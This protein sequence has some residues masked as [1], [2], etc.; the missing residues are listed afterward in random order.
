[1]KVGLII[2]GAV[3]GLLFFT[4]VG[5][6]GWYMNVV[7]TEIG[8]SNR[9]DG[10]LNVVET[11]L[12][13]MRKILKNKYKLTTEYADKFIAVVQANAEGRKGGGLLKFSTESNAKIG[14]DDKMYTEMSNSIAG[15]LDNFKRAQNTLTDIWQVHKTY[16]KQMPNCFIIGGKV[17]SKP[18]MISSEITKE[19]IKTKK[20]SDDVM[21]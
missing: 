13:T 6:I 5:L 12:D 2:G 16:C 15:E 17:K 11:Q 3:F 9:Y 14:I 4:V 21:N 19:A 1:M 10:Q 8:L 20:L 7:N 18:E